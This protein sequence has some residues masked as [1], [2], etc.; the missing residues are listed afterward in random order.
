MA[1][2]LNTS[3]S[4]L[5]AISNDT[6]TARWTE[7][8]VKYKPIMRS[9][10]VKHFPS[11]DHDDIIQETMRALVNA[12]PNYHYMPDKKGHFKAYLIGIVKHKA[13]DQIARR[14][15]HDEITRRA[16]DEQKSTTSPKI[17]SEEDNLENKAL[18]VAI[19]QFL[20]DT[21]INQLHREIF[22][23]VA[24]LH[25]SPEDVA[26]QFGITR[27]NVDVIKKRMI[28]KISKIVS[29]MMSIIS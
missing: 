18:E 7:F 4:L 24:L 12:L 29:Q 21:S 5:K 6:A 27:N 1:I 28:E 23:H 2:V 26:S 10:L 13:S 8:F 22:R 14:K 25:E 16:A 19:E 11:L 20:A 9:F 15:R 3:I 17:F